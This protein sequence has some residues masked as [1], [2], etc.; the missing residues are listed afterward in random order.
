MLD[1]NSS[2][3]GNFKVSNS[4][5]AGAKLIGDICQFF[6]CNLQQLWAENNLLTGKKK[7]FMK[8]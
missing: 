6:L 3:G 2:I 8:Q 1:I 5:K 7:S 4:Y